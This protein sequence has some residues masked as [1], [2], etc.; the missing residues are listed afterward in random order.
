[1]IAEHIGMSY[2][3]T[4]K[5]MDR[6]I[7]TGLVIRAAGFSRETDRGIAPVWKYSLAPG[8]LENLTKTLGIFSN[9]SVPLG[10]N[11]IR[12]RILTVRSELRKTAGTSGPVLYLIGGAADGKSYV[13]K[14]DLIAIGRE[15]PDHPLSDTRETI[16][17]PDDYQAVTRVS[18]PHA[19]LI[20]TAASWQI[21][22]N[23]STGGTYLNS[24][25]LE[26]RK[27][28]ALAHGDVIDLSVGVHAARFLC[29][30]DE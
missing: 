23:V 9:I 7:T 12:Q 24:L 10:Y 18:K 15:D 3:N 14:K 26:P 2:Q 17:L 16:V 1:V 21:E 25:R 5:H 22:D 8:G 29:I 11:D 20:R 13:L 19:Y 30:L 4:K 6:L 28:T 27:K